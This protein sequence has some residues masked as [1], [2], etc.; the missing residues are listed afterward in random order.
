MNDKEVTGE[1]VAISGLNALTV[2]TDGGLDPIIEKIKKEVKAEVLDISTAE[3]RKRIA[4]LAYKVAKSKTAIDEMGKTLVSGWKE[5]AKKVDV[6]RARAWNELESLQKE[7]RAPLTEWEDKEK[8]RI[9][10]HENALAEL[11]QQIAL[12]SDTSPAEI[13]RRIARLIEIGKSRHW[14]EFA[15]RARNLH[16]E[17]YDILVKKLDASRKR[18]AEQVEL[19]RLRR[20]EAE[21]KQREHEERLKAEAAAKA[22]AEVEA[23]AKREAEALAAKVKAEQEAAAKREEAARREK[24]EAEERARKAEEARKTAEVKAEADR[25]AAAEKARQDAIAADEKAKREAEAAAQR[26]RDRIEAERRAEAEAVAKR[27]ADKAHTAKIN[28][29]ALHALLS[30]ITEN[31]IANK[32]EAEKVCKTIIE[33]IA[34][35]QVPHV[36]I[37]Y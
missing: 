28:R 8:D 32:A 7:I 16:E 25:N 24:V 37:Q 10:N 21:R 2:F 18:E 17:A 3:G 22:K 19:D 34:K 15:L 29:E 5:Q 30:A 4:S 33:A 1:L 36:R 27:E 11:S 13:E 6:E 23:Q 31:H 20:D 12:D 26:E 9:A 14:E 35:G